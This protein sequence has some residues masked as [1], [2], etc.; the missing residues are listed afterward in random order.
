MQTAVLW[1]IIYISFTMNI[2]VYVFCKQVIYE[3]CSENTV[4]LLKT[5]KTELLVSACRV[6]LELQFAH[7]VVAK[8]AHREL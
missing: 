2:I 6:A 4:N 3:T 7:F 5:L 1:S 8:V